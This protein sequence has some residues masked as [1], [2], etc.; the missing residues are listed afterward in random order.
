MRKSFRFGCGT[1]LDSLRKSEHCLRH[2]SCR[3]YDV[4][5]RA[6]HE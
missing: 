2:A 3:M 5:R 1:V 4:L 6:E